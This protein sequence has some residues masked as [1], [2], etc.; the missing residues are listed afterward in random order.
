MSSAVLQ[1]VPGSTLDTDIWVDLPTRAYMTLYQ[2]VLEQQG[3]PITKTVY[4]LS[5]DSLVNFV[6]H[7]DGLQDFNREYRRSLSLRWN[8]MTIQVLPLAR[9]LA[10]KKFIRR[11][12]D[13]VHIPMIEDVLWAQKQQRTAS[14]TRKR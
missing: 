6:F 8:G 11:P 10:S 13:L 3:K 2:L 1:G 9:I 14:K 12:K 4:S 7:V 5:D